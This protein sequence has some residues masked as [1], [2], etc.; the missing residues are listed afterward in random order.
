MVAIP[1]PVSSLGGSSSESPISR[2]TLHKA[3]GIKSKAPQVVKASF[4][5]NIVQFVFRVIR[6]RLPSPDLYP[7]RIAYHGTRLYVAPLTWTSLSLLEG[8]QAL[9][10]TSQMFHS[11]DHLREDLPNSGGCVDVS[12]M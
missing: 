6:D 1:V 5:I 12:S 2:M 4:K 11:Q 3:Q 10:W 9:T 7:G 8:Q